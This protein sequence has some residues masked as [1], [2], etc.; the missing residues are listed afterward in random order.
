MIKSIWK[1]NRKK[2]FHLKNKIISPSSLKDEEKEKLPKTVYLY[3]TMAIFMITILPYIMDSIAVWIAFLSGLAL[4]IFTSRMKHEEMI[5]GGVRKHRKAFLLSIILIGSPIILGLIT[6]VEGYREWQL[7]TKS[8]LVGDMSMMFFINL[9]S[10]PMAIQNARREQK[11]NN[12]ILNV[13]PQISI[14]VPAYNEEKW[15]SRTIE[16]LLEADYPKKEIIIVDD[17]STDNTYSKAMQYASKDVKIFHKEN[18]GKSSAMNYGML[19]AK[20]EIIFTVD[21]DGVINRQALKS[22]VAEFT[23]PE[24][25]GVAGNVKVVNRD[26]LITHCQALEYVTA[27]NL[28]KRATAILGVVQVMPGPLT[29]FRRIVAE[30][31]GKYDKDT[32]TEDFDITIKILKVGNIVQSN[33][34]GI[35]YTEAPS[36]IKGLY[37]QR[38]RW[39]QGNIQTFFKHRNVI[40][41]PKFGLLNNLI[42]PLLLIHTFVL[43]WS[44][45]FS[46]AAGLFAIMQGEIFYVLEISIFFIILQTLES[47]LAID[48]DKEDRKLALY[49]PALIYGYKHLLDLIKIK[50]LLDIIFKRKVAWTSVERVGPTFKRHL[51]R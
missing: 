31:V 23:N 20:G 40:S 18:G 14:I 27:I 11:L 5:N 50:A 6:F 29:A 38:L 3:A 35:A 16:S 7:W 47:L 32:L 4:A 17:G 39:Y 19:F 33:S 24:V 10:I 37:K 43:P 51:A 28:I 21:G 12:K 46:L 25:A 22:M 1:E 9:F 13:F 26:N 30:Q 49:S 45:I 44:G 41:N 48:I 15:I 42:F 2:L 36:T 8:I 34:T